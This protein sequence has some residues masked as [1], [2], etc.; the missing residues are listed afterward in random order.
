VPS[1]TFSAALDESSP[2][3]VVRTDLAERRMTE[4]VCGRDVFVRDLVIAHWHRILEPRRQ[5]RGKKLRVE[6]VDDNDVHGLETAA[7]G[8]PCTTAL[9]K[10]AAGRGNSGT[11][12]GPRNGTS[13]AA[14]P[15]GT[16]FTEGRRSGP[17]SPS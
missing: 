8:S 15:A 14:A 5:A 2:S 6:L 12:N 9:L 1:K 16:T 7:A 13:L 3:E 4:R 17:V 11:P 10:L